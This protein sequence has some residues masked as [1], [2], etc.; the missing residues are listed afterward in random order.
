MNLLAFALIAAVPVVNPQEG[1]PAPD[2]F[3]TYD[4]RTG[5][6]Y[7]IHSANRGLD[8]SSDVVEIHRSRHAATLNTGETKVVCTTNAVDPVNPFI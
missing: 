8:F 5:Y 1:G 2:P 4:A 3:V 7:L 6:Y